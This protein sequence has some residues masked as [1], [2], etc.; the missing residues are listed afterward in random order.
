M[1]TVV[2]PSMGRAFGLFSPA[3][4]RSLPS[5]RCRLC[6]GDK[7]RLVLDLGRQPLSN[8]LRRPE[9]A[10][11]PEERFPLSVIACRDC[12]LVQIADA[13]PPAVLFS[14]YAYFSS[15]SSSWVE[16]ARRYAVAAIERLDLGP[17]T[18]VV[19]AASN[20][21]YLLNHFR[22]AGIP[23][24]GI[25]PAAN[26][27]TVARAAGVPTECRFFGARTARD[28]VSRG[29]SADLAV[30]NNVMAHVPDLDDFFAGFA[31]LLAPRGV[32]SC[33]FPH[34]LRLL[35]E[36]Q[37]DTIYHEHYSYLSL[38]VIERVAE[39]HGLRVFDVEELP[40]HGGSLRVW[41]QRRDAP[42]RRG[43][44]GTDKV[45]RDEENIRSAGDL[46][47]DAF[48]A[49][50]E[51]CRASF[52]AFI[53][54]ARAEGRHIVGYGAAAKGVV[55]LNSCG[56]TADDLDYVVDLSPHKQ[57]LLLPGCGL[58]IYPPDRVAE[59][60]PDYLLILPWNLR[61]E[62]M[63]QMAH[64]RPWGGRFVIAVPETEVSP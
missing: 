61:D 46:V 63:R 25:E 48:A 57:G 22:D 27:A 24:L 53:A 6:G 7:L 10:D 37:F 31:A 14:D 50:V 42:L 5:R 13:L 40:T 21:G 28:L 35:E 11:R 44:E 41:I 39:A 17:D 43:G 56:I 3:D 16:H 29:I 2:P 54:A 32:L 47:Y 59:T 26:I 1:T 60:R 36:T 64:I 45:R 52:R 23:V 55:L 20:D 8:A 58:P 18:R 4:S 33:E 30:A 19:E 49:R 12:G 38:A 9:W 51:R 15:Y 62:I 34:L